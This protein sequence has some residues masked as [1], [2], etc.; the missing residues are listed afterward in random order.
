M[1]KDVLAAV[2]RLDEPEPLLV[3]PQGGASLLAVSATVGARGARAVPLA[4]A[5]V[6]GA[7]AVAAAAAAVAAAV[8]AAPAEAAVAVTAVRHD[9]CVRDRM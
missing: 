5:A 4:A 2:V 9:A 7:A 6:I 3:P 1:A 8:A